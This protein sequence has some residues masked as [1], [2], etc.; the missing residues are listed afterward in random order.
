M[1]K[2]QPGFVATPMCPEG[3]CPGAEPPT[4]VTAAVRHAVSSRRPRGRYAVSNVDFVPSALLI[5]LSW[6][7]PDHWKDAVVRWGW[8]QL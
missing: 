1:C 2:V 3:A 5:W 7:L 4:V 8:G 6:V